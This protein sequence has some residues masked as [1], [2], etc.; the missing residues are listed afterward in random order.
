MDMHKI[1]DLMVAGDETARSV[2]SDELAKQI[3][4]MVETEPVVPP[5]EE[6]PKEKDE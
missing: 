6:P 4:T 1:I 2:F 3:Q 5:T